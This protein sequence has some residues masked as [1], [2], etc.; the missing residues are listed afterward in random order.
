MSTLRRYVAPTLAEAAVR[1]RAE[2]GPDAVIL[3]TRSFRGGLWGLFGPKLMEVTVAE[4]EAEPR[5]QPEANRLV[6]FETVRRDVEAIKEM[7]GD[8]Q[9]SQA[10]RQMPPRVRELYTVLRQ[11]GVAEELALRL[12]GK[13]P[14]GGWASNH[15]AV[16]NVVRQ[17]LVEQV[18]TPQALTVP[19]G[20]RRTVALVGPTGVGK[21]TTIAKLTAQ[22]ALRERLKVGVI[23]AD[24]RRIGAE[25]QLRSYCDLFGIPLEVADTP[26]E[27]AAARKRLEQ[28]DL[29]L[30]DTAGLGPRDTPR[31][32]ALQEQLQALAPD[33]TFLVLS[34]TT[35]DATA[36]S[37]V[38]TMAPLGCTRLLGTKLDETSTPGILLNVRV[39]CGL[40]ISYVGLGQQVPGDLE[41]LDPATYCDYLL[42]RQSGAWEGL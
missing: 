26:A 33:E 31:F 11:R 1:V 41:P 20:T 15:E 22:F 34:L 18:G 5:P 27:F 39:A 28:C 10:P 36:R 38:S 40:P 35:S 16:F 9:Q 29:V 24:T 30:A 23:C 25:A 2:L 14:A 3:Q 13:P 7:V 12:L 37:V 21:T 32:G 17:R 4:P 19:R 6:A 8:L 42:G